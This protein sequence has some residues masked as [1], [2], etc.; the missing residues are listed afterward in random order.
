[1]KP[2]EPLPEECAKKHGL[3]AGVLVATSYDGEVS[4][5]TV[6]FMPSSQHADYLPALIN[7]EVARPHLE[8]IKLY[9]PSPAK[10]LSFFTSIERAVSLQ[11]CRVSSAMDSVCCNVL[12]VSQGL[13]VQL[14]RCH[15]CLRLDSID[16]RLSARNLGL[17][18]TRS[19]EERDLRGQP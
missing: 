19:Q 17:C 2:S 10:V 14:L 15:L 6:F 13:K 7:V 1:M 18:R 9:L 5:R 12:P 4:R 8:W 11:V 3:L 16:D